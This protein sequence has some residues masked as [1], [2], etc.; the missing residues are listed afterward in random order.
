[1]LL[2][3]Q[4]QI[5]LANQRLVEFVGAEGVEELRGMR[6]GEMLDCVHSVESCGGCGTTPHCTVCGALRAITDA[7]LGY[8]QTQ[9]CLMVR[10]T[11]AGPEPAPLEVWAAP[12]EISGHRFTLVCLTDAAD[13]AVRDRLELSILPQALALA[14]E[15]EA[16]TRAAADDSS[17]PEARRRTLSLLETSSKRLARVMHAPG[18]LAAAEAGELVVM[19]RA[20]SARELLGRAADEMVPGG[21]PGIR[22]DWPPE[23][24]VVDTD[25]ELARKALG[26]ILVNALQAAPLGGTRA[27]FRIS[28]N[29]AD[30]WVHNPCEM[31]P[32]VVL[33]VFSR[34][35]TT[36]A[37]G[38][39][40]GTYMARLITERYLGGSLTFKSVAGEGTTFTVRLPGAGG[41]GGGSE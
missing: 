19:R 27:G 23:D 8:G 30:F 40:Y 18:E 31:E 37:P 29:H 34:G 32:A 15:T 7:Q 36:K 1:M 17:T 13:R 16:L 33:Q 20:V 41:T 38:R 12:F 14:A 10:Q 39:G 35:F 3:P 22:L 9:V 2:N 25:P 24:G 4:R 21:A 5:V 6:H 28:Q 26:E 11:E